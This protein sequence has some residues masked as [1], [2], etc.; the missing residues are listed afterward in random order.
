MALTERRIRDAKPGPKTAIVWDDQVRGL[1]VRITSG[2]TKSLI[3]NYRPADASAG[4]PWGASG[5]FR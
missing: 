4:P 1:G 5:R 3:L 2:G